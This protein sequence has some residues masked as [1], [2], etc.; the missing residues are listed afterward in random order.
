MTLIDFIEAKCVVCGAK[1]KYYEAM[2]TNAFGYPDL[3]TR[4]PEMARSTLQLDV[5]RCKNCGY[6]ASDIKRGPKKIKQIVNSVEYQ[7]QLNNNAY[8]SLSN[9]F[10][11]Q[12]IIAE[13]MGDYSLAGWA[14][15]KAAW[16][17]DDNSPI[18]AAIACRK[19][20][21]LF[22]VEGKKSGQQ[23]ANQ[24]GADY[25]LLADLCRRS[26]QFEEAS[27]HAHEGINSKPEE[28]IKYLLN[29]QLDL[30]TAKDMSCHTIDECKELDPASKV[31]EKRRLYLPDKIKTLFINDW[32][33]MGSQHFYEGRSNLFWMTLQAFTIAL[34][35]NFSNPGDFLEYFKMN[36][37]YHYDVRMGRIGMPSKS[38]PI[39]SAEMRQELENYAY[40]ILS[41]FLHRHRPETIIIVKKP[42]KSKVELA[43]MRAALEST[44][45]YSLY[46]GDPYRKYDVELAAILKEI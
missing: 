14:S 36:G 30:I 22:F 27:Y 13:H 35:I 15:L 7:Q 44:K 24:Q 42:I 31:E 16:A 25:L 45:V 5:Q 38:D 20:A 32:S 33:L 29:F 17:C 40:E 41:G 6:C 4:P 19:R 34:E 18:E 26:G 37:Y 8:P 21:S 39:L 43:M 12:S 1:D 28:T 3:D 46:F 9:S 10:L 23:F 11:C 2:S